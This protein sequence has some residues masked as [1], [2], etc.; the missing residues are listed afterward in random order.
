MINKI[1]NTETRLIN[2]LQYILYCTYLTLPVLNIST[3]FVENVISSRT[4]Q[5]LKHIFLIQSIISKVYICCIVFAIWIFVALYLQFECLFFIFCFWRLNE[6]PK[7]D[8][9]I[10]DHLIS[11]DLITNQ[12]QMKTRNVLRNLRKLGQHKKKKYYI[13]IKIN[14]KLICIHLYMFMKVK[15]KNGIIIF[16]WRL[17]VHLLSCLRI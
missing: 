10:F 2:S 8:T 17:S 11:F 5:I 6:I 14:T 15:P 1:N 16:R 9:Q 13:L 7:A 12:F 3:F 4:L